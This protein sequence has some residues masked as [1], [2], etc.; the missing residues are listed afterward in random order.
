MSAA[1]LPPTAKP[2]EE[3]H[4]ELN[5]EREVEKDQRVE[6]TVALG[7]TG[8]TPKGTGAREV[9]TETATAV[10]KVAAR[11]VIMEKEVEKARACIGSMRPRAKR[12][13]MVTA[14][15]L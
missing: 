3:E 10:V 8:A 9:G 7:E 6:D 5:G 14:R 2:R 13:G 11:V 15:C 1:S 12:I 4:Q